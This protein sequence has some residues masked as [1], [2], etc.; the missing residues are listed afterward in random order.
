[1]TLGQHIQ[2]LRKNAGL[3]QESLGEALGVSRQ[4]VSKWEADGAIPELDTL[5]AM[6]RLFGISLG[7]LL[8]LEEPQHHQDDEADQTDQDSMPDNHLEELLRSYAEQNQAARSRHR[9]IQWAAAGL[10]LCLLIG[11]GLYAVNRITELQQ[12]LYSLESQISNLRSSVNQEINDITY[13]ISEA[14]EEQ[15]NILADHSMT[16]V[17]IDIDKGA[18]LYRL[19]ASLKEVNTASK[20]QFVLNY[21][22]T[23]GKSS[24]VESAMLDGPQFDGSVWLPFNYHTDVMLLVTDPDGTQRTQKMD[25]IYDAHEDYYRLWGEAHTGYSTRPLSEDEMNFTFDGTYMVFFPDVPKGLDFDLAVSEI[26]VELYHNDKLIEQADM[27]PIELRGADNNSSTEAAIQVAPSDTAA[28]IAPTGEDQL[29][30]LKEVFDFNLKVKEG[31]IIKAI[32]SMTDNHGR[33]VYETGDHD[34]AIRIIKNKN[35][36][37]IQSIELAE[38]MLP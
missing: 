34:K 13:R 10:G 28:A 5:I 8:Q 29:Y 9:T 23:D 20:G 19:T 4:A 16:P 7:Q 17:D 26:K 35:R 27:V 21:T 15:D 6:S 11:G 25:V 22:T 3:S 30:G 24:T 36:F 18:L 12:N 2:F 14:L 32:F 31:D 1:M 33:T 38:D 37:S